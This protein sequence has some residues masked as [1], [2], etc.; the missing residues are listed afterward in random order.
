MKRQDSAYR[1]FILR[2]RVAAYDDQKE[3]IF[4]VSFG[5]YLII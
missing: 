2:G 5:R 3:K 4:G 1:V